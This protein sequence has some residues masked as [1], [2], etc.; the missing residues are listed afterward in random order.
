M[1]QFRQK[2]LPSLPSMHELS[3]EQNST[4]AL[5]GTPYTRTFQVELIALATESVISDKMSSFIEPAT[6]DDQ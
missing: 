3:E 4:P 2:K 1:K 6:A 5:A